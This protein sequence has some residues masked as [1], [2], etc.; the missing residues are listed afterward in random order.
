MRRLGFVE[1]L[2]INRQG[3]SATSQQNGDQTSPAPLLKPKHSQLQVFRTFRSYCLAHL[4]FRFSVSRRDTG[5]QYPSFLFF[6]LHL[7]ILGEGLQQTSIVVVVVWNLKSGSQ[8]TLFSCIVSPISGGS[9]F[10]GN[11]GTCIPH[12]TALLPRGVDL[13]TC[14]CRML[15]NWV[16]RTMCE[17]KWMEITEGR[18][19]H[20]EKPSVLYS[21]LGS[22]M[23]DSARM[24]WAGRVTHMGTNRN[25]V[26]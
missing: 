26:S 19:L 6:L 4:F 12:C 18:R 2:S 8:R 9:R 15:E 17:A 5:S 11:I 23:I 24:W 10:L 14:R 21:S 20:S 22:R 16:L 13:H 1:T 3:H 7:S 25:A